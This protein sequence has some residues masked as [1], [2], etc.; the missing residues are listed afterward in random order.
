[1]C[2]VLCKHKHILALQ[3][4]SSDHKT[5]RQ[6]HWLPA[7]DWHLLWQMNAEACT[8]NHVTMKWRF[9]MSSQDNEVAGAPS[10]V[11]G[12]V[13]RLL[14]W[15]PSKV[16][17]NHWP[18]SRENLD[19]WRQRYSPQAQNIGCQLLVREYP[20]SFVYFSSWLVYSNYFTRNP[21]W[22]L[23]TFFFILW[24]LF[25]IL[26]TRTLPHLDRSHLHYF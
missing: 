22:R 3:F 9:G 16:T 7:G 1:M 11:N 15:K 23:R 21:Y 13:L 24:S 20:Q 8:Q 6:N 5:A 2:C 26:W 10:F 17:G 4:A 18:V 19:A 14:W 12:A 25:F